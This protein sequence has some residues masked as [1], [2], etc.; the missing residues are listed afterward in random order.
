[1]G[2]D[3]QGKLRKG[4]K[5]LLNRMGWK[6]TRFNV[7]TDYTLKRQRFMQDECI[8]VVLDVGANIGQYGGELRRYHYIGAIYSFEPFDEAF[9]KLQRTIRSDTNW[10]AYQYAVGA[11]DGEA[12]LNVTAFSP[13]NSLLQPNA[14]FIQRMPF[15]SL[16]YVQEVK[17]VKLDTLRSQILTQPDLRIMLKVDTQGYELPVL[18]GAAELLSKIHLLELEV[19]FT[20]TYVGQALFDEVYALVRTYGFKIIAI[21]PIFSD[22]VTGH[23]LQ[24][25]VI[26]LNQNLQAPLH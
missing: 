24:A 14:E 25:D 22:R 10:M 6:L 17:T 15:A 18:H 26:F 9:Q 5:S 7:A 1:M 19:S 12:Q 11:V 21:S 8:N 2:I 4:A 13:S 3:I 16:Q 20:P 23:V